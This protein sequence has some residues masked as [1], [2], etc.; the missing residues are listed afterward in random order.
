[1]NLSHEPES[2]HMGICHYKEYWGQITVAPF[3]W[4]LSVFLSPFP[5]FLIWAEPW[6]AQCMECRG[7]ESS[8]GRKWSKDSAPTP[9][10]LPSRSELGSSFSKLDKRLEFWFRWHLTFSITRRWNSSTAPNYSMRWVESMGW[11]RKS[12]GW[13][14]DNDQGR[15]RE[16]QQNRLKEMNLE[17]LVILHDCLLPRPA[18]MV[19]LC[20]IP[21]TRRVQCSLPVPE[22]KC[23][24][25]FKWRQ[26]SSDTDHP[27][28]VTALSIS[29]KL[30][31]SWHF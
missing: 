14:Q 11:N 24:E 30:K 2:R 26:G 5:F 13:M 3:R 6:A 15:G 22:S 31:C 7:E 12:M 10:W 9:G 28:S 18:H 29:F 1:M 21:P 4:D 27:H 16:N 8:R 20:I 23:T 19:F 25:D 17:K